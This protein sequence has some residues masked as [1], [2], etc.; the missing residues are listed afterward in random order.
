MVIWAKADSP[1]ERLSC[2]LSGRDHFLEASSDI[3]LCPH[4][5]WCGGGSVA[6]VS[7]HVFVTEITLPITHHKPD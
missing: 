5:T 1:V 2:K 4:F 7:V 6:A 3:F